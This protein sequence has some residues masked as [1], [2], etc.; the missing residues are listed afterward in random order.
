MAH[1][2]GTRSLLKLNELLDRI[3]G[4]APDAIVSR[5]APQLADER[6]LLYVALSRARRS[7]V[8]TAVSGGGAAHSPPAAFSKTWPR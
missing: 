7:L 3:A 8:L 2:R 5:R 6:R 4:V 1:P